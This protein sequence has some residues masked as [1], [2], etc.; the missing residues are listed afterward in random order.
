MK[1]RFAW[2]GAL[3]I[4]FL[5]QW[6]VTVHGF[7]LL[8]RMHVGRVKTVDATGSRLIIEGMFHDRSFR[9]IPVILEPDA[10][11]SNPDL[12]NRTRAGTQREI[13]PGY[14]VA[15]ECAESGKRHTARKVTI[16]STDEEERLQRAVARAQRRGPPALRGIGKRLH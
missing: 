8:N 16:T 11:I 4:L 6:A 12:M 9:D 14:Y 15:L 1:R 7:S 2:V 5:A 13:R 3:A 10:P